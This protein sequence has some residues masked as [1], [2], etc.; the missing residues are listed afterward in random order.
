VIA[1]RTHAAEKRCA[2]ALGLAVEDADAAAAKTT[3]LGGD[4]IVPPFGAPWVR[5]AILADPQGAT[6]AAS[7]FTPENRDLGGVGEAVASGAAYL[8]LEAATRS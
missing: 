3:E 5:M 7:R 8:E 6:F 2:F 4:V 1:R